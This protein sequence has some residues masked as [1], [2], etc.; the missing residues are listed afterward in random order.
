MTHDPDG[1]WLVVCVG[2]RRSGTHWLQRILS[3]H[4]QVTALPAETHLF[5]KGI[6]PLA[7]R[8]QSATPASPTVGTVYVPAEQ[9]RRLL[10]ELA[11]AILL[12]H[13]DRAP[14]GT[15][16]LLERTPEHVTRIQLVAELYPNAR[17]VHIVRDGRDVVRSLVHQDFGP[18]DVESAAVEW[19]DAVAT[20][21]TQGARVA[22]Y[23]EVRYE[24]LATAPEATIR[25]VF[26]RLDLPVDD[27]V[28]ARARAEA[29]VRGNR[30]GAPTDR[31]LT[32]RQRRVVERVADEV[33]SSLEPVATT[34]SEP[35]G[36]PA[37]THWSLQSIHHAQLAVD[38]LVAAIGRPD[39]DAEEAVA[40]LV[41]PTGTVRVVQGRS[42]QA[43]RAVDGPR[44]ILELLA[45]DVATWPQVASEV[46]PTPG[47]VVVHTTHE[48]GAGRQAERTLV[49]R[50]GPRGITECTQYR[51]GPW[52]PAT[53]GRSGR[54]EA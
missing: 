50:L 36:Q 20:G 24:H 41:A 26:E 4:P 52:G 3:T 1:G 10:R 21:R 35:P 23:L 51:H 6:G 37:A 14:P 34:R 15:T 42:Q 5:S 53:P 28:V 27:D 11:D 47:M 16:R 49:V 18:D 17:F 19:C 31:D 9:R 46:H 8:L 22:H 54:G 12:P 44:A 39:D 43:R 13:L 7:D 2:A 40:D 38:H 45:D 33:L 30:W 29:E 32:R 25:E 48:D